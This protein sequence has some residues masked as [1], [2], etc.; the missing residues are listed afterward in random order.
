MDEKNNRIK[1]EAQELPDDALNAV[2]GGTR[3][4]HHEPAHLTN[5]LAGDDGRQGPSGM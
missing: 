5:P 3:P 1:N 4:G 2:S